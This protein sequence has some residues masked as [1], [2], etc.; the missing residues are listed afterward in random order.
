MFR[1]SKRKSKNDDDDKHPLVKVERTTMQ[2]AQAPQAV[3]ERIPSEWKQLAKLFVKNHAGYAAKYQQTR[4]RCVLSDKSKWQGNYVSYGQLMREDEFYFLV[5][6]RSLADDDQLNL[7][8]ALHATHPDILACYESMCRWFR[9]VSPRF[10]R[11]EIPGVFTKLSENMVAEQ[12]RVWMFPH[13]DHVIIAKVCYSHQGF[14][15]ADFST[16]HLHRIKYDNHLLV[17]AI[18]FSIASKQGGW[19]SNVLDSIRELPALAPVLDAYEKLRLMSRLQQQPAEATVK[20]MCAIC[21]KYIKQ[22]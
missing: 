13:S 12:A 18:D 9:R 1:F 4:Q 7:H 2:Y 8:G 14:N 5:L 10:K 6:Q 19:E 3:F 15:H 21:N 16:V 17:A 11:V 22:M 20:Q